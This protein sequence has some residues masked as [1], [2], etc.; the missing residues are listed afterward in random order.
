MQNTPQPLERMELM[1]QDQ[2]QT[3]RHINNEFGKHPLQIQ[4]TNKLSDI[5]QRMKN[6]EA[7]YKIKV[8]DQEESYYKNQMD[9]FKNSPA[10]LSNKFDANTSFILVG[11]EYWQ[12]GKQIESAWIVE[13]QHLTIS[14]Y[15]Q[16]FQCFNSKDGLKTHWPD[17]N[18]GINFV[19]EDKQVQP[20]P[21]LSYPFQDHDEFNRHIQ[22][23]AMHP[24]NYSSL[25][26]SALGM[27]NILLNNQPILYDPYVNHNLSQSTANNQRQLFKPSDF[28]QK[29]HD[30]EDSQSQDDVRVAYMNKNEKQPIAASK[31]PKPLSK[32]IFISDEDLIYINDKEIVSKQSQFYQTFEELINISDQVIIK[33]K[34]QYSEKLSCG[35]IKRDNKYDI[36]EWNPVDQANSHRLFRLREKTNKILNLNILCSSNKPIKSK[37][38]G[39][40]THKLYYANFVK[41]FKMSCFCS[42]LFK[43][44]VKLYSKSYNNYFGKVSIDYFMPW[45]QASILNSHGDLIFKIKAPYCQINTCFASCPLQGCDGVQFQIVDPQISNLNKDLSNHQNQF[46]EAKHKSYQ[47][48]TQSRSQCDWSSVHKCLFS[49]IGQVLNKFVGK[50]PFQDSLGV[51]VGSVKK[52]YS[53]LVKEN[54]SGGNEWLIDFPEGSTPVQRML[55][56]G[57]VQLL[58]QCY[59]DRMVNLPIIRCTCC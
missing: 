50:E 1:N 30:I 8:E 51:C 45:M 25:R 11:S 57:A 9:S 37:L 28:K 40:R 34:P 2:S 3:A 7:E 24:Q 19:N 53:N 31:A 15:K 12:Y 35:L 52:R 44:E 36:Y 43:P 6:N 56:I 46:V 47:N 13:L 20:P 59:F 17:I 58:D 16:A 10:V 49:K 38:I 26:S 41:K 33:K 18:S 27:N 21:L 55:I 39:A 54:F 32:Y 42:G 14:K 23:L 48:G 5:I 29:T 22:K 4:D